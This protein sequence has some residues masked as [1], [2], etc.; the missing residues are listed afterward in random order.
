MGDYVIDEEPMVTPK[1]KAAR[2]RSSP[3]IPSTR[4]DSHTRFKAP[5]QQRS[6]G[7]DLGAGA[8]STLPPPPFESEAAVPALEWWLDAHMALASELLW[9]EQL[10]DGV[11]P[12]SKLGPGGGAHGEA[13]RHLVACVE[14]VRDALYELYCDAADDRMAPLVR[15]GAALET[16]VRGAY[17]WCT[18]VVGL[19]AMVING[20]RSPAGPDW[21]A[22]KRAFR[23]A[24]ARYTGSSEV[25]R[26][27][28][29]IL[30]VDFSSPIEPLRNLPQDLEHLFAAGAELHAALAKRFA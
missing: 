15:R 14:G 24:S 5:F 4:I 9:L 16:Q 18:L 26:A 2:P 23:Q 22:A 3:D 17:A 27:A 8:P 6:D 10:L 7:A 11:P 1:A 28:V 20:L 12:T 19:L 25:L 30:P 13:V 29:R 21:G